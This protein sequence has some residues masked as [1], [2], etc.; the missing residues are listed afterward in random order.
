MGNRKIMRKGQDNK[1]I[2]QRGNNKNK[3]NKI[4]LKKHNNNLK[5]TQIRLGSA[6]RSEKFPR[7]IRLAL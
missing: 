6:C 2:S 7:K 1:I 3:M 5:Q 4:L